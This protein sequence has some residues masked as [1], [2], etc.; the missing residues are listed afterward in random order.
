MGSCSAKL[1]ISDDLVLEISTSPDAS[2]K[3]LELNLYY[4]RYDR[5]AQLTI[6]QLTAAELS[7]RKSPPG[8]ADPLAPLPLVRQ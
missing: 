2:K 4:S 7:K 5:S 1:P 6:D 3:L 8:E